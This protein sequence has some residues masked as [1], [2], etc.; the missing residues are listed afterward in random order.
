MER[1][2][3]GCEYTVQALEYKILREP[4]LW[5]A[6]GLVPG[7]ANQ[8]QAHLDERCKPDATHVA[9]YQVALPVVH[10]LLQV[11]V[12]KYL[13][14]AANRRPLQHFP[15]LQDPQHHPAAVRL[16]R[17]RF[18]S[19]PSNGMSTAYRRRDLQVRFGCWLAVGSGRCKCGQ[20]CGFPFLPVQI[21]KNTSCTY[22]YLYF[23][24]VSTATP[25]PSFPPA[26]GPH[27]LSCRTSNRGHA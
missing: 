21:V 3:S 14:M 25:T 22:H 12:Y 8:E 2:F 24:V 1:S 20:K 7:E 19:V 10:I 5:Y 4:E 6:L 15:S 26:P 16:S 9:S 23:N 11:V 18:V 17:N 13:L 27:M